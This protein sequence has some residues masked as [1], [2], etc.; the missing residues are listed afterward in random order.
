[1]EYFQ[2][3]NENMIIL[4]EFYRLDMVSIVSKCFA[5]K[6]HKNKNSQGIWRRLKSY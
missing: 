2:V 3:Q 6:R 4:G 1:M 5:I